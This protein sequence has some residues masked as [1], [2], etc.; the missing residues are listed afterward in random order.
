MTDG[1]MAVRIDKGSLAYAVEY[2]SGVNRIMRLSSDTTEEEIKRAAC[3]TAYSALDVMAYIE[4]RIAAG[5][6]FDEAVD[7]FNACH[8]QKIPKR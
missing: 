8:A 3:S 2:E 6:T 5:K 7:D 4:S 1:I